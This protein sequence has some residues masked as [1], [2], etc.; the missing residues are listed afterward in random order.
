MRAVG[1]SIPSVVV[2]GGK[3]LVAPR[4]SVVLGMWHVEPAD[5]IRFAAGLDALVF[6]DV[7]INLV[8]DLGR[9]TKKGDLILFCAVLDRLC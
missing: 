8:A 5:A 6:Q 3:V 4:R 1:P 7:A 9:E 2:V